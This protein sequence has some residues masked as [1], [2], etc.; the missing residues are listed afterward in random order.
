MS[1]L[2][3]CDDSV[4]R[5]LSTKQALQFLG[6]FVAVGRYGLKKRIVNI[7]LKFLRGKECPVG[8]VNC[9]RHS[10]RHVQTS[11]RWLSSSKDFALLSTSE[12]LFVFCPFS[13]VDSLFCKKWL[14]ALRTV[15]T[16]TGTT[17]GTV[18]QR[19]LKALNVPYLV[20]LKI[21]AHCWKSSPPT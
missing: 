17:V 12:V 4:N 8:Y 6:A 5:E 20:T 2:K 11:S 10:Q 18:I 19:I 7:F 13:S 16:Q 14:R 15:G 21:F 3:D 1:M 9:G